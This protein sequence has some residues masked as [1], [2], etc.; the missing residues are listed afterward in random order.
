[1]SRMHSEAVFTQRLQLMGLTRLKDLFHA[2][3]WTTYGTFAFATDSPPGQN[4]DKFEAK[5][6]T[7]LIGPM[8]G[9][10]PERNAIRM[11]HFESY[12]IMASEMRNI[13]EA[14]P[15]SDRPRTLAGA[16]RF[17]RLKVLKA[18]YNGL[19]MEIELE[20]ELEPADSVID[21]F[22]TMQETGVLRY[23]RWDEIGSRII[24]VRGKKRVPT[25]GVDADGIVRQTVV[26]SEAIADVSTA[27]QLV[28]MFQRRGI[29][30]HMARLMDYMVRQRLASFLVRHL[31][32]PPLPN[33]SPVFMSRLARADEEI[34]VRMADMT[35]EGLSLDLVTGEYPLNSL[36][37]IITTETRITM[38]LN[39]IPHGAGKNSAG[40]SMDHLV[41][42]L[43]D[44]K[45]Q[46]RALQEDKAKDNKIRKLEAALA[47]ANKSGNKGGGKGKDKGKGQGKDKGKRSVSMPPDLR[48]MES[49]FQ[50]RPICFDFNLRHGCRLAVGPDGACQKGMHVCAQ[51]GCAGNHAATS[52]TCP[53]RA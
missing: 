10:A 12:S 41:S 15:D 43:G 47:A 11:L 50:D 39:P 48:G 22:V 2:N 33:H 16:E 30:M 36:V 9:L 40:S 1:M 7:V 5:V 52:S 49:R 32:L 27:L 21:K 18:K 3:G 31:N 13:V 38:L 17:D 4:D 53:K 35:R 29:A 19:G 28:H 6:L 25:I 14:P 8:F 45:K 46:K 26:G 37:P 51:R 23:L 24:E 20:P 34:F 44:P 42:G